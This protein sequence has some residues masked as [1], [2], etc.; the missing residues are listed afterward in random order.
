MK[1]KKTV[2]CRSYIS[3]SGDERANE[4]SVLSSMH[5]MFLRLHNQVVGKLRALNPHWS[6]DRLVKVSRVETFAFGDN[7]SLPFDLY[8]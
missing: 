4:N 5:T 2:F 6:K 1:F 7:A 8:A 3:F